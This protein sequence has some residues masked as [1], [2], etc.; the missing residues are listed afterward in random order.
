MY[1]SVAL[2][3]LGI[4][5]QGDLTYDRTRSADIH[6]LG[7]WCLLSD[8]LETIFASKEIQDSWSNYNEE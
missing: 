5:S 3:F 7:N 2:L 1:I 6:T 4:G 8:N